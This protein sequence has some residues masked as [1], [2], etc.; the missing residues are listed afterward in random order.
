M[1]SKRYRAPTRTRNSYCNYTVRNRGNLSHIVTNVDTPLFSR[2]QQKGG[3]KQIGLPKRRISPRWRKATKTNYR[4]RWATGER[5]GVGAAVW[6]I[7]G[8]SVLCW[9]LLAWI[10]AGWFQ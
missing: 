7:L 10:S 8:L 3:H 5:L 1:R 9:Y 2:N 4:E 6:I